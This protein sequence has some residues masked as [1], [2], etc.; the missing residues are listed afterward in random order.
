M[1]AAITKK[2]TT[3]TPVRISLKVIL[4]IIWA[5]YFASE[6]LIKRSLRPS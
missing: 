5:P 1:T 6:R 3:Q 2:A 4:F